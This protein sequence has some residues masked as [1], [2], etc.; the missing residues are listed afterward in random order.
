MLLK[1]SCF[2]L[3]VGRAYQHIFWDIPLRTFFWDESLLKG[4]AEFLTGNTWYEIVTSPTYDGLLQGL[5]LGLGIWY[6]GVAVLCLFVEKISK[7]WAVLM[8]ITSVFLVL[9]ALLYCKDKF[10]HIAQ[11]FE[12]SSQFIAPYLLY[13]IFFQKNREK[14]ILSLALVAIALTFISHGLYAL[15]VYPVPGNFVDMTISILGISEK[16]ALTFLYVIGWLDLVFVALLLFPKTRTFGLYYCIAWGLITALARLLAH[17]H[18]D[19]FWESMHQYGFEMVMRLVHGGLPLFVL[20]W[21]RRGK[22]I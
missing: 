10:Y 12:Y 18:V 3:L 5:K 20:L 15:G 4:I 6:L 16:S 14:K 11:F 22:T 17:V 19:F 1:L 21:Q 9:L 8:P 13:L 2:F 7:K